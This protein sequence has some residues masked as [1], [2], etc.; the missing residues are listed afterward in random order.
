MKVEIGNN[1]FGIQGATAN[2]AQKRKKM[3]FLFFF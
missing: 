2:G 1:R 3:F